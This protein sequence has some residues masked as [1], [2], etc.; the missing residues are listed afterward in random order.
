MAKDYAKYATYRKARSYRS[1]FWIIFSL[2]IVLLLLGYGLFFLKSHGRG[3][4][5]TENKLKQKLLEVPTPKPPQPEF[6]FY[7]ILPQGNPLSAQSVDGI[8][9]SSVESPPTANLANG[10][11]PIS[12]HLKRPLDG[13]LS[14]TPEQLAMAEAKKQLDQEMSQLSD[15]TYILV[16]GN[17]QAIMQAQQYQAQALLRG[18]SVKSKVNYVNGGVV[19]YQLFMGPYSKIALA[20]Q[21]QKRLN[22]AGIH[23][24]LLKSR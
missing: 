1:R 4:V 22:A 8:T 21:E 24:A 2:V 9:L 11:T 7:N 10:A 6:D 18:F 23:A 16:L 14:V 19:S 20:S 13:L 12:S 3:E 17:F 5:Q 15:A